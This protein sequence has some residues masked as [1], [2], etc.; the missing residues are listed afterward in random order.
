MKKN[1]KHYIKEDQ[2]EQQIMQNVYGFE[3][4]KTSMTVLKLGLIVTLS[5]NL[6]IIF[7]ILTYNIL[8]E[9]QTLALLELFNED[10][11]I[12]KENFMEVLTTFYVEAPHLLMLLVLLFLLIFWGTVFVIIRN[13]KKIRRKL[14]AIK[15]YFNKK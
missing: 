12:I 6:V 4:K 9:Q 3:A 15:M 13:Y 5:L 8:K 10:P 7:G 1:G 2:L 14:L 11:S